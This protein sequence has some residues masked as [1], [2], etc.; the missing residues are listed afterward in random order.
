M[1]EDMAV[2][3]VRRD[4]V[5]EDMAVVEVTEQDGG[6]CSGERGHGSG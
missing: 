6:G 4:A 2:V 3:E 5:R 1:R